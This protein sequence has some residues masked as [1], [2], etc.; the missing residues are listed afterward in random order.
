MNV[1]RSLALCVFGWLILSGLVSYGMFRSAGSAR[2]CE[3]CEVSFGRG[4]FELV[5]VWARDGKVGGSFGWG[6][7][8]FFTLIPVLAFGAPVVLARVH[9]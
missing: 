6:A 8:L 4:L 9:R 2:R 1:G 3:P 5:T 7:I